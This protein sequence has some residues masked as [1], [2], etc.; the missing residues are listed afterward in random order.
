MPAVAPKPRGKAKAKATP[1][2]KPTPK[3]KAK[4]TSKA[5]TVVVARSSRDAPA[6]AANHDEDPALD[7]EES[8]E[9]CPA[10]GPAKLAWE[11]KKAIERIKRRKLSWVDNA[12]L[13][14]MR[15]DKG[16]SCDEYLRGA[17]G[18]NHGTK[19]QRAY[20]GCEFFGCS[21]TMSSSSPSPGSEA[22]PR[23]TFRS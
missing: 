22:C 6:A 20:L 16:L 1:K 9:V 15:T 17:L 11:Q 8:T 12:T 4:I 19:E 5:R 10:R 18:A 13:V 23:L 7:G 3:A 2:P 21:S 14:T